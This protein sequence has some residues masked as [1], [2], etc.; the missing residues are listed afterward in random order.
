HPPRLV[1]VQALALVLLLRQHRTRTSQHR[2]PQPTSITHIGRSRP[3]TRRD[4]LRHRSSCSNVGPRQP[5]RSNRSF[6]T[7]PATHPRLDHT[8]TRSLPRRS[9]HRGPAK[10]PLTLGQ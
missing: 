1:A 6:T 2:L 9:N 7:F 4:T 3:S 10:T 5:T 8:E